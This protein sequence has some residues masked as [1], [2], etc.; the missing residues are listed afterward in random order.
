[1]EESIDSSFY[2][3]EATFRMT[4]SNEFYDLLTK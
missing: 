2:F 4:K 1:M 3:A